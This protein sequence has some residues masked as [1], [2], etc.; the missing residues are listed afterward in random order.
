MNC[1]SEDHASFFYKSKYR[2]NIRCWTNATSYHHDAMVK[3]KVL[4]RQEFF[5]FM[6]TLIIIVILILWMSR[7]FRSFSP[8]SSFSTVVQRFMVVTK[9]NNKKSQTIHKTYLRFSCA[10]CSSS[11]LAL[12]S[13]S[14]SFSWQISF[15]IPLALAS[16]NLAASSSVSS[17]S[18]GNILR[19]SFGVTTALQ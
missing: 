12:L 17:S 7:P 9:N 4:A 8:H 14:L 18:E 3:Q 2:A 1:W 16:L 11:N 5:Q 6:D 10:S 19:T 15:S 13:S